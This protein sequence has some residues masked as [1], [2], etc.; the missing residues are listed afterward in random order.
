MTPLISA[1]KLWFCFVR[2][3]MKVFLVKVHQD[4][5]AKLSVWVCTLKWSGKYVCCSPLCLYCEFLFIHLTFCNLV[6]TVWETRDWALILGEILMDEPE[7]LTEQ[8]KTQTP[9]A[10]TDG[11]NRLVTR[12]NRLPADSERTLAFTTKKKT[13]CSIFF[14]EV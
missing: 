13:F 10:L 7:I 8:L 6:Q 1:W 12:S 4:F 5:I 2:R 3:M 14:S 9:T 11:S